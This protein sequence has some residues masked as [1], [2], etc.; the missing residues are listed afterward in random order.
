VSVH[1][2]RDVDPVGAKRKII[3]KI[4]EMTGAAVGRRQVPLQP[5]QLGDFH[6]GRDRA[7]DIPENVIQRIVNLTGFSYRSMVHPNDDIASLIAR[8][9]DRE[10]LAAASTTTSEQVASKPDL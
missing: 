6:F 8:R 1:I 2:E 5:K 10:R 7:A 3:G 9:A 4:E